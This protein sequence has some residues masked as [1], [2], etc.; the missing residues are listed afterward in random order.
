MVSNYERRGASDLP[1]AQDDGLILGTEVRQLV[2]GR[3]GQHDVVQHR[4]ITQLMIL[5]AH[6]AHAQTHAHN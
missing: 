5:W 4:V 1:D 2:L 6:H 3:L